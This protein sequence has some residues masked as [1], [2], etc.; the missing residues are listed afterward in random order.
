[1]I[2]HLSEVLRLERPLIGLDLET[3]TAQ[4][5]TAR[6]VQISLEIM[7]P[8]QPVKLWSS[9]VNPGV[10]IP[11]DST[12]VHG[13]T[14]DMVKDAPPFAA[15]VEGFKRGLTDV[16][17]AG[18]SL[19]F[20]LP[21]LVEEFKRAGMTWSYEGA[22]IVDG[23]RLW[24]IAQPRKLTDAVDHWLADVRCHKAP[25]C[26][27]CPDCFEG[28]AHDASWDIR[29]TTLVIAQQ[30]LKVAHL[31]R[32]VKELH[33]L[34]SPD[35]Y[36]AEGKLRWQGAE[37][38]MGFGQHRGV[39]MREVPRSYWAFIIRKDFSDKVKD[40]ARAALKGEFPTR[41]ME[42]ASEAAANDSEVG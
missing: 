11:P 29:S 19:R 30:L 34:C 38:V 6:I 10:P 27:G 8:G 13:I 33:D 17:F 20:D 7:R 31:P 36:D 39:P 1:M 12:K 21:V 41:T 15:G 42:V 22:S 2:A 35:Y 25:G 18:F 26:P 40:A 32:T 5:T 4:P 28:Q 24:Q 3:T 23:F 37:V 16:D 9:I 14:D